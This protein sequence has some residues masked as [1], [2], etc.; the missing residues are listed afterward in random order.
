MLEM[1]LGLATRAAESCDYGVAVIHLRCA[2]RHAN[3]VAPG[4][5]GRVLG[6]MSMARAA[7]RRQRAERALILRRTA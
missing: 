2:L 3:A 6:L 5:R 7:Q 4:F 1:H